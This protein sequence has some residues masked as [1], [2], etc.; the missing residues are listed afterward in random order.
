M[1]PAFSFPVRIPDFYT[2]YRSLYSNFSV[3]S[4]RWYSFYSKCPLWVCNCEHLYY[5]LFF[6]LSSL[7]LCL[8]IIGYEFHYFVDLVNHCPDQQG[9]ISCLFQMNKILSQFYSLNIFDALIFII[10][11][12]HILFSSLFY[13]I[14]NTIF[15][16]KWQASKYWSSRRVV[17]P[18]EGG[19]YTFVSR[20]F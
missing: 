2:K 3:I 7:F 6:L 20:W 9:K 18:S 10:Y 5:Q 4:S 14:P 1:L 11:H 15:T 8:C 16:V 13:C 17:D 19:N 12:S